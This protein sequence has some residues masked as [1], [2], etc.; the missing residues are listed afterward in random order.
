MRLQK[1]EASRGQRSHRLRHVGGGG[2]ET[3][4]NQCR[5]QAHVPSLHFPEPTAEPERF[6]ERRP[7]AAAGR[8]ADAVLS[9]VS[10]AAH[11]DRP[12]LVGLQF[13]PCIA[14]SCAGVLPAI[15]AVGMTTAL[16]SSLSMYV[17]AAV[18][19]AALAVFAAARRPRAAA[20]SA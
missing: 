16:G 14:V 2:N 5:N 13:A 11:P 3:G 19:L 1:Y 15:A 12:R 7:V 6:P 17:D 10:C 18:T 9:L 8:K 20:A 4:Q